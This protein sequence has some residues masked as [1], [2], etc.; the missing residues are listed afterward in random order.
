MAKLDLDAP[1]LYINR[2]LSWL[3]FNDRVLQEGL[4]DD[5]PL[6]ER[7]RFLAIVSS[8]LDEFFM[9]RVAGLIQQRAVGRR[10]DPSGLTPAQQLE[11]ISQRAHRMVAEQTE[12]IGRA[13]ALVRPRGL[14]V[15]EPEE[16]TAATRRRCGTFV[17]SGTARISSSWFPAQPTSR[18]SERPSPRRAISLRMSS[19]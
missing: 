3:E 4:S 2:E 9:V 1:E 13:L 15:L 5:L 18:W 11:A 8:N 17:A 19:E 7:L 14:A 10:R 12:G 6:L 16:W